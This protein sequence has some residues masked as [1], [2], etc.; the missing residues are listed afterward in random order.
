M[1]DQ[2]APPIDIIV[3]READGSV[4]MRL[5]N[6]QFEVLTSLV[7]MAWQSYD[8]KPEPSQTEDIIDGLY[9]TMDIIREGVVDEIRDVSDKDVEDD[10]AEAQ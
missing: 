6:Q 10:N 2:S 7:E 8:D 9:M 4:T 1:T 5:G 3:K